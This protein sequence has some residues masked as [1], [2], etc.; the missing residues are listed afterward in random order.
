MIRERDIR[1]GYVG[2]LGADRE[3]LSSR[4]NQLEAAAIGPGEYPRPIML[5]V[6]PCVGCFRECTR[7]E[8]FSMT[9]R[10]LLVRYGNT[11]EDA[12]PRREAQDPG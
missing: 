4:V 3:L 1:N 8:A 12:H 2:Q 5:I 9:W 10:H 7:R 6:K 11:F